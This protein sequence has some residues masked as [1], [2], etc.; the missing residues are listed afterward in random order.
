MASLCTS[1]SPSCLFGFLFFA[2]LGNGFPRDS[3]LVLPLPSAA[4]FSVPIS[5]SCDDDIEKVGADEV[6]ELVD[7]PGTTNGT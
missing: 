7:R 5:E 3:S 4:G 6:E 2:G 1:S